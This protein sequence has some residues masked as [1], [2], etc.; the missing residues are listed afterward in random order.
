[1]LFT[2]RL[3]RYS[4]TELESPNAFRMLRALWFCARAR[5][6]RTGRPAPWPVPPLPI[7]YR[8]GSVDLRIPISSTYPSPP[9]NRRPVAWG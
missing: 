5:W 1:M 8:E 7:F 6:D 3:S 9:H 2:Y 4:Y